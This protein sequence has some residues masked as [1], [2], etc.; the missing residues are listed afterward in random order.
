[1]S[2]DRGDMV[3]QRVAAS[4]SDGRPR[5][6]AGW[7][8]GW[9]RLAERFRHGVFCLVGRCTSQIRSLDTAH[10]R[11]RGSFYGADPGRRGEG[12]SVSAR[13]LIQTTCIDTKVVRSTWL[14]ARTRVSVQHTHI[15]DKHAWSVQEDYQS[16]SR[17]LRPNLPTLYIVGGGGGRQRFAQTLLPG[18]SSWWCLHW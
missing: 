15:H 8:A 2:L 12:L 4:A 9:L 5:W 7:L 18:P 17:G 10:R 11:S 6:L 1:M 13:I 14:I 3:T 16:P